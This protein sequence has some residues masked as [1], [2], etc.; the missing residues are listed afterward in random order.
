MDAKFMKQGDRFVTRR[1]FTNGQ[2][3]GI[4]YMLTDVP[5]TRQNWIDIY[6]ELGTFL[7]HQYWQDGKAAVVSKNDLYQTLG[8]E[9][10]KAVFCSP[11]SGSKGL[12]WTKAEEFD[13]D[14][15]LAYVFT[16]AN[17]SMGTPIV[18]I[19][20]LDIHEIKEDLF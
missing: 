1:M 7:H 10:K 17:G 2:Y 12:A 20:E 8:A 3:V 15:L 19:S 18:D 5:H 6:S 11:V 14:K 16:H 9:L 4:A 13:D